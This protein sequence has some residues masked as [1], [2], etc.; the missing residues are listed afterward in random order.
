MKP[1]PK[2]VLASLVAIAAGT[3]G[4][5]A[6]E[7]VVASIKPIHSLVAAVME[8]VGSPELIV[9]G[10]GS[11]HVYSMRPSQANALENAKLVFWVG[12]DLEVFFEKPLESLAADATVVELGDA[13]GLTRLK[14]REGGPFEV[15]SHEHEDGHD[16]A[17]EGENHDGHDHEGEHAEQGDQNQEH[18]DH[19]HGGTDMH[20][21][22]DPLNA[23]AMVH[24]IE[25]ALAKADPANA[26]RYA[27]NAEEVEAQLDALV[28]ETERELASVKD[29]PFIV[30]H[31]AYQYYENRFG[32]L[33]AGSI[34]VSPE[35]MPGA[36]RVSEMQAKVKELGAVCIFAEP[37]FEPKLVNVIAEG[38]EAKAGV[39][40][41]LGAN[42][43]DGPD[44]YF[45]LIRNLTTSLKT[46]L[47]EAS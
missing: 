23:K 29:K 15:H 26:E 47:S 25:E 4:A 12:H 24:E 36:Q 7:G 37:Q 6:M 13:H 2:V 9:E 39:L 11:P 17:A 20:L 33:A 14:F 16:H 22:L 34:T 28:G 1:M 32:V 40:D 43:A 44:L 10:A 46:C 21:W 18:E 45:Q 30:F 31:D 27:A 42:L 35:A 3:G 41:P 8:G 5:G 38:T 19:A